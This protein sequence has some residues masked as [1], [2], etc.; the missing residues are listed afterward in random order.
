[1][2]DKL[3]V[4]SVCCGTKMVN[5]KP[6]IC[7]DGTFAGEVIG[8]RKH[9]MELQQEVSELQAENE[10][11]KTDA[12]ASSRRISNRLTAELERARIRIR[13]LEMKLRHRRRQELLPPQ[14]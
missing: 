8:L 10:R 13:E 6:C 9:A 1:M 12:V 2:G 14:R 3:D 5:H 11:L 7:V 4:C